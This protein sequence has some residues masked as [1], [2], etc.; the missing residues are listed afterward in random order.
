[1]NNDAL[2]KERLDEFFS[3]IEDIRAEYEKDEMDL[4]M[5]LSQIYDEY[6][7]LIEDMQEL[8]EE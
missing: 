7:A 4:D 2:A 8:G 3:V 1:M 6:I 5:T